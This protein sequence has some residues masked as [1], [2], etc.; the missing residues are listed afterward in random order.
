MEGRDIGTVV[1]PGAELKVFLSASAEVRGRRRWLQMSERGQDADLAEVIAEVERRDHQDRNR[2][3][4]P[5]RPAKDA[6]ILDTSEMSLDEVLA[7]LA[8]LV[9]SRRL[10]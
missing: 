1:F 8:T 2:D 5:L 4:A 3:V 6:V 7:K 10:K 9:E